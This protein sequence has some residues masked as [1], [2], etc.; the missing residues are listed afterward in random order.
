MEHQGKE[1]HWSQTQTASGKGA[2]KGKKDY[3][4]LNTLR[5]VLCS[6]DSVSFPVLVQYP[7]SRAVLDIPLRIRRKHEFTPLSA[8]DKSLSGTDFRVFFEW[9]KYLED[10]ENEYIR[11]RE[12]PSLGLYPESVYPN[13]QLEAVRSALKRF[14]PGFS[15]LRVRRNPLHMEIKKNGKA[16]WV[17]S[18]SDGEKCL[19]ALV[20]DLARRFAIANQ[21]AKINPLEA[22]G[23]VLIDE[24]DLHLHPEWQ[25]MIVPRMRETF[26]N[27]QFFFTTH[28][29]L[30]LNQ[31][32]P[33]NL[34]LLKNTEDGIT[35]E[36]PS[37]SFGKSVN[38]I[39]EDLMGLDS[40]YPDDVK[41]ALNTIY[42]NIDQNEY[43]EAEKNI[44]S[45]REQG[46]DEP[47]LRKAE[48]LIARRKLIGK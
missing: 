26:P 35:A 11:D 42:R 1:Y 17:D 48:M 15:D 33:G 25:R 6:G 28:S 4:E 13:P 2:R 24:V 32:Q 38:R 29:P 40:T 3:E 19:M 10:I 14:L 5:D 12:Q 9:F 20:G 36:H 23:I 44:R 34:Y 18:L 27:C 22:Q 8:F 43:S 31:L 39:L 30:V 16:L 37:E 7:V 21:N 47:E 41:T 46:F 45:L